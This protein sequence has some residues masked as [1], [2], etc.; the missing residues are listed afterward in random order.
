MLEEVND[1]DVPMEPVHYPVVATVADQLPPMAAVSA[2]CQICVADG[3]ADAEIDGLPQAS[4]QWIGRID[5]K[6]PGRT[7]RAGGSGTREW[8]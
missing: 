4:E 5:P 3:A 6:A 8:N 7:R 2:E 1:I